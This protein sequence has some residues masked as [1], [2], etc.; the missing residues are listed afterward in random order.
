MTRIDFYTHVEDRFRFACKLCTKA[1]ASRLRVAVLT[2]DEDATERLDRLLWSLPAISFVPHVRADSAL[3]A[4]TPVLIHHD[5]TGFLH[6]DL[7]I[8]LSDDRPAVFARFKRLIEI[9][10]TDEADVLRARERFRFYRDRGYAL[11]T[12]DMTGRK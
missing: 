8:N 5:P 9:V 2:A 6:D 1:V 10:S 4:V 12:H 7:L 3:A 11:A